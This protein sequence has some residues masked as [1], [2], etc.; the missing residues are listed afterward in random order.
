MSDTSADGKSLFQQGRYAEAI[1]LLQAELAADP[2]D[3]ST[4]VF[5]AASYAQ[6]GRD[7][8]ALAEFTKLTELDPN[9]PQHHGNLGIAYETAGNIEKAKEQFEKALALNANYQMARQH[10]EAL[11]PPPP[12]AASAPPRKADAIRRAP[13][14]IAPGGASAP[15]PVPFPEEIQPPMPGQ[16]YAPRNSGGTITPPAGLNWGAFL[17]PHFWSIAHS[18]WLWLI[19]SIFVYPVAAIGLLITGNK[20]AC[21]NRKFSSLDEFK[22]VQKA[23]LMWGL[24]IDGVSLIP[25]ILLFGLISTVVLALLGMKESATQPGMNPQGTAP[26][27]NMQPAQP[28][29][30]GGSMPTVPSAPGTGQSGKGSISSV[31]I[32]PKAK[33]MFTLNSQ[34]KQTG[35]THTSANYTVEASFDDV[36]NFYKNMAEKSGPY[37]ITWLDQAGARTE[38]RPGS[39]E[40]AA[41]IGIRSDSIFIHIRKSSTL[42]TD[43]T[44]KN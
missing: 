35:A 24:I 10:L 16:G 32:Y 12:P 27:F 38:V 7:A 8:E 33:E 31:P 22:K 43:F 2:K 13:S 28:M 18:A 26:T 29:P 9:N 41:I 14:T 30:S 15:Q 11:N 34:D 20:V 39:N 40:Y 44:L 1:P 3:I 19:L 37:K 4:R 21:E 23:W 6:S 25:L 36:F 17:L 42:K 5:L